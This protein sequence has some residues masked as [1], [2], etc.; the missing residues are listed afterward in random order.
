VTKLSR[1]LVWCGLVSAGC[2][3]SSPPVSCF[4][5]GG[6]PV[7]DGRPPVNAD[8]GPSP[9]SDGPIAGRDGA[10]PPSPDAAEGDAPPLPSY[11]IPYATAGNY[12]TVFDGTRYRP[13]F[14]KGVN[15]AVSIPGTQPGELAASKD[16]YDRWLNQIHDMGANVIRVYTLHYPRFYEAVDRHN[17][18]HPD[19]PL[20]LLHGIWL[21]EDN[22]TGDLHDVNPAFDDAVLE[23]VDA[24]HGKRTIGQRYGRAFGEYKTDMSRWIIGWL[25][26]REV[27]GV[28][29]LQ[30]NRL[31][32]GE[33]SYAGTNFRLP[34]GSP[35]EVWWAERLDRLV[36]YERKT[37][38]VE[39][40]VAVSSWPTLDPLTHPSEGSGS[41]EDE[42]SLDMANL[43]PF[44]APA[45][46]FASF[47]IYPNYPDFMNDDPAYQMA[48]DEYGKNSYLAY[49]RDLKSHY[50]KIPVLVAEFG[51]SSSWGNAHF[52]QS[53]MHHGGHDEE[54][55]GKYAA[56]MVK[57][58][59]DSGY[60]GA[61]N[62]AWID[63][64]W[65]ST[66]ICTPQTFPRAR[67][68]LWHNVMSPEQ[69]YGLV[70]FDLPPPTFQ[71][72]PAVSGGGRVRS[73]KAD[74]NAEYFFV[75]LQVAGG[76]ADGETLN[77]GFDTYA[78]DRGETTLPNGV[79]SGKRHEIAL[80]VTAPGSAQLYA[81]EAYDLAKIW[82][83]LAAATPKQL[84]HSIATDG[85]PWVPIRWYNKGVRVWR[86]G[87]VHQGT[88]AE[89]GQLRTRRG[90]VPATTLDAVVLDGETVDVR[91]PW[92]LLQFTDPTTLSVLDDNQATASV[93]ETA[94]S[95]GIGLSVSLAGELVE[96]TRFRWD[97]WEKVPATTE[98]AKAS[99]PAFSAAI[100]SMEAIPA[101]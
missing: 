23:V 44:G 98:R 96:T 28:E 34:S 61:V 27:Y 94:V 37:Y 71:R 4:P 50:S 29:A 65:K 21:T 9:P 73:V 22:P 18:A 15:L 24:A 35:T 84:W 39:R 45:G 31:H 99:I 26:G 80:T 32:P 78:D 48:E 43:D 83:G 41:H 57:N 55:Q 76:L 97:P 12:L 64:W 88:V 49:L 67:Y 81:T 47:H 10:P 16:Q 86:D 40:P 100:R 92:M 63:E 2:S 75:R 90:T 66:W 85:A 89:T 3:S 8:G 62:F 87:S 25:V 91:I 7:F 54:A 38:G 53:G 17:R 101:P 56:R 69:N 58:I 77:I 70:A 6:L 5:D 1:Y 33:T 93:Q 68:P 79:K 11:P 82:N 46:F 36:S 20:Y 60:A 14:L 74:A 52:G 13:I 30:T 19:N 59:H 51:I 72:W 42:V 95:A